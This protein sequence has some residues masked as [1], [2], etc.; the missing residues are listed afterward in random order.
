MWWRANRPT[1]PELFDTE[2]SAAITQL[3]S[4]HSLPQV[5]ESVADEPIRRVLLPKTEQHLYY[6]IDETAAVV[7]IHTIWG[8]RRG[9]GPK[10]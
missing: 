2:L 4:Q 8:A 5:F 7:L 6:S 1:A 10:L 3:E 9:S